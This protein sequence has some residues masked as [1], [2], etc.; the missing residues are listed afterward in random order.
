MRRHAA[1]LLAIEERDPR[2]AQWLTGILGIKVQNALAIY[3]SYLFGRIQ[4]GGRFCCFPVLFLLKSSLVLVAATL[5]A[6]VDSWRRWRGGRRARAHRFS[7]APPPGS[8]PAATTA[9]T[10]TT[11]DDATERRA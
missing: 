9:T 3:P 1:A 4:S 5:W 7:E 10:A 2:L 8:G 6:G 11:A